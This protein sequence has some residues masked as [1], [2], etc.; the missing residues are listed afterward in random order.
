MSNDIDTDELYQL[1][2][3]I[4]DYCYEVGSTLP[5]DEKYP[6]HFGL[7]MSAFEM[8]NTVAEAYGSTDPRDR[9]W[10]LGQAK[11]ALFS[12]QNILQQSHKRGLVEINPEIMITIK[13]AIEL[14]SKQLRAAQDNIG[15]YLAT[16][17]PDTYKST[18]GIKT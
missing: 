12:A 6:V 14:V 2:I 1:T 7:K 16:L 9:L 11:R 15:G 8:T 3:G 4:A 17:D 10:K 18:N 13:R 5:E